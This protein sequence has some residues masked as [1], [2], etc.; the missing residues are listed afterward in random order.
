MKYLGYREYSTNSNNNSREGKKRILK[1]TVVSR[2]LESF[3][4]STLMLKYKMLNY[5]EKNY[6][7][8]YYYNKIK[9]NRA[10]YKLM[11][12]LPKFQYKK[13]IR[14]NHNF[15][16]IYRS[17]WAFMFSMVIFYGIHKIINDY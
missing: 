8:R 12:K 17:P 3:G 16:I 1:D 10:K 15:F 14:R 4:Y 11:Q 9:I 5:I 2:F 7:E 6:V 13:K